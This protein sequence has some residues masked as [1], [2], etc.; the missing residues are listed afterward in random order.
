MQAVILK[1]LV[2][3]TL[4]RQGK[5]CTNLHTFRTQHPGSQHG[6]TRCNATGGNQRKCSNCTYSRYQTQSGSLLPPIMPTGFEAFGNYCINTRLFSLHGKTRGRNNMHHRDATLVQPTSPFLRAAGR[7]KYNLHSL[8]GHNLH[9]LFYLGI[10]QGNIHTKSMMRSLTAFPDM[11]PQRFGMHR[12]CAEQAQ[13]SRIA[14]SS[15]K[16]PAATPHHTTLNYRISYSE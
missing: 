8:V 9:Y 16:S 14:Y 5:A 3:R 7:C 11:L 12:T 6:L 2:C 13:P 15:S 10:H 1:Y 4:C